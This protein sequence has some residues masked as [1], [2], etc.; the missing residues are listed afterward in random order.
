MLQKTNNLIVIE[1]IDEH[2]YDQTPIK[3]KV[4]EKTFKSIS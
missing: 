4:R 3:F 2:K 1:E